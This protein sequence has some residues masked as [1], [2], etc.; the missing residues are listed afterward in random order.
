VGA[1]ADT[2]MKDP[3]FRRR[4]PSSV[5]CRPLCR[6]RPVGN[7][8]NSQ[9]AK[10]IRFGRVAAKTNWTFLKAAK[11]S[12]VGFEGARAQGYKG[13]C[14]APSK[15]LQSAYNRGAYSAISRNTQLEEIQR[16]S[17]G[18]GE[19][20]SGANGTQSFGANCIVVLGLKDEGIYMTPTGLFRSQVA[21]PWLL[22]R[23]PI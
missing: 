19:A 12:L 2:C 21:P 8:H 9:L 11:V 3:S 16:G 1:H 14:T 23:S 17:R 22:C 15:R 5:V 7:H 18:F 10:K 4:L 13:A 20:P 6:A